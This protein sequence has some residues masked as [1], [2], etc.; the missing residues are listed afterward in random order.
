MTNAASEHILSILGGARGS[1]RDGGRGE[2]SGNLGTRCRRVQRFWEAVSDLTDWVGT[3]EALPTVPIRAGA[4]EE[5]QDCQ[6]GQLF[7][8]GS[9]R[10]RCPEGCGEL[11]WGL[12]SVSQR[13]EG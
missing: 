11:Q 8:L 6:E 9:D 5:G 13:S 1:G 3:W 4:G 10:T 12:P 7:A 2:F